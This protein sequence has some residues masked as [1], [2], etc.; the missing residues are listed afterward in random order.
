MKEREHEIRQ[1]FT[2]AGVRGWLHATALGGSRTRE[3]GLG[4]DEPEEA[5]TEPPSNASSCALLCDNPATSGLRVFC[6][7]RGAKERTTISKNKR[8]KV[9]PHPALSVGDYIYCLSSSL[10]WINPPRS[11]NIPLI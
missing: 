10:P 6:G 4:P 5:A 2:D 9:P 11:T 8:G 1:V 7:E 3:I